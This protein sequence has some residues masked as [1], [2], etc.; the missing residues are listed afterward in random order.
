MISRQDAKYVIQQIRN[1]KFYSEKVA[2]YDR[3]IAEIDIKI[4]SVTEPKSP[5][6]SNEPKGTNRIPNDSRWNA[7]I[8][9]K[10]EIEA[11]REPWAYKLDK[12]KGYYETLLKCDEMGYVEDFFSGKLNMRGLERKYHYSNAYTTIIR[13]IRRNIEVL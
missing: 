1:I 8:V 7:L 5:V 12:A 11:I 10:S 3:K 4:L 6:I 13:I 2:A 9:E